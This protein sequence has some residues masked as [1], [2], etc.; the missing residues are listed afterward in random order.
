MNPME[1]CVDSALDTDA[2]PDVMCFQYEKDSD[3]ESDE[4]QAQRTAV[5]SGDP[6]R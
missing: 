2:A 1:A 4:S 5:R 6:L 3:C